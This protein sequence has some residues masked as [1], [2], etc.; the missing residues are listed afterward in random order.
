MI[1]TVATGNADTVLLVLPW[2][3]ALP[4]GVSV[5]ARN[6]LKQWDAEGVAARG[7]VSEW[8]AS[9]PLLDL[10]GN[11][12]FRFAMVGALS[13]LGL[14]KSLVNVPLRLWR[15]W[16]LL[17]FFR[18][19]AVNFHYPSLDAL[20]VA[21]LRCCD[22]AEL[23]TIFWAASVVV[24]RDRCATPYDGYGDTTLAMVISY[25]KFNHGLFESFGT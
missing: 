11:V 23:G 15:T 14:V 24:S 21:V 18:V 19:K 12:N 17:R 3:P 10:E 1:K 6:L 22:V 25:V 9:K 16:Q 13:G 8:G 2:S 4:G 5:V 20:G 7:V